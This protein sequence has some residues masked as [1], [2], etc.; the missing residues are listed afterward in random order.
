MAT[1]QRRPRL[2]VV[3]EDGSLE[4]LPD[5]WLRG[6]PSD[7]TWYLFAKLCQELGGPEEALRIAQLLLMHLGNQYL[8]G[9]DQRWLGSYLVE[10]FWQ[11]E[12]VR[13]VLRSAEGG[14]A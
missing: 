12:K 10:P 14:N 9:S 5:V 13:A 7:R 2:Q 4:P 8:E 11:L 1:D 6:E 3:R